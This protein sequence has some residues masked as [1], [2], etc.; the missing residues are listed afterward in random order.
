MKIIVGQPEKGIM[1]LCLMGA[2]NTKS[3]FDANVNV[4]GHLD[5]L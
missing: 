3:E 1:L 4:A 5:H 2:L